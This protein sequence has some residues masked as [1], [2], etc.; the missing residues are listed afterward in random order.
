MTYSINFVTK[1]APARSVIN[2]PPV[3]DPNDEHHEYVVLYP[4]NE[5][6]I[7][8]AIAPK[9]IEIANQRFPETSW[10]F[11]CRYA[12]AQV[13]Q[14]RLL[15]WRSKLAQFARRSR[16]ELNLPDHAQAPSRNSS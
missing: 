6:E 16:I 9:S 13:A 7:A 3:C 8:D 11:R 2:F 14:D 5:P 4:A 12:G 10:I 1:Y 15:R